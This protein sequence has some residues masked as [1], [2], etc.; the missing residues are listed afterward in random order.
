MNPT[1]DSL[2]DIHLPPPVGWWPPA[3]GWWLLL[4]LLTGLAL[5]GFW[6]WR[7]RRLG[8]GWLREAR[9]ELAE[10]RLRS[11]ADPA[12]C[13]L[14][15]GEYSALLRRVAL[16]TAPRERV[17]GL[18]GERWLAHLDRLAGAELFSSAVGRK[19]LEAQYRPDGEISARELGELF[20]ATERLLKMA[21]RRRGIVEDEGGGR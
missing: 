18:T 4:A 17:A 21:A 7:R 12:T 13:R 5:L 15:L 10:L 2:R 20:Q 1:A 8:S 3:P 16:A 14:R 19:L 9:T 6:W 11:M